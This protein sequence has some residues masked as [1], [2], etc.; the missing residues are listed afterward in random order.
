MR[1]PSYAD[2]EPID[3]Q[4]TEVAVEKGY[5]GSKNLIPTTLGAIVGNISTTFASDR[6]DARLIDELGVDGLIAVT[7]DLEMQTDFDAS[8]ERSTRIVPRLSFRV[9]GPPNGYTYGPTMYATGV[10]TGEGALVD[11]AKDA[12]PAEFLKEVVRQEALVAAFG[13][14]LARLQEEERADQAY[15]R[16]W[17]LKGTTRLSTR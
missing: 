15:A 2:L 14:A 11:D 10:I 7:L 8:A 17:E 5:R 1:A 12:L 13:E 6:I 16:L 4:V 9:S 3:D